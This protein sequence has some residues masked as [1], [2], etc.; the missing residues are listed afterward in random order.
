[1]VLA[2]GLCIF[3]QVPQSGQ[4]ATLTKLVI[5]LLT[6][7]PIKTENQATDNKTRRKRML[8]NPGAMM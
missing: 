8:C 1:V 7:T 6:V 4:L 5:L 3:A 2:T